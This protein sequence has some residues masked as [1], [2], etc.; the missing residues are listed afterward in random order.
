[1]GYPTGN[2][3][4]IIIKQLR[5]EDPDCDVGSRERKKGVQL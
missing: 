3:V 1:M 2:Q 4:T 5:L